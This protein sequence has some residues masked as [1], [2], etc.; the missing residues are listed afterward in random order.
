M[1]RDEIED[2]TLGAIWESIETHLWLAEAYHLRGADSLARA[3]VSEAWQEYTRFE[4][5]LREFDA[6]TLADRVIKAIVE[7]A[8]WAR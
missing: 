5:H 6:G 8:G 3:E 2:L 4:P 7:S 1:S